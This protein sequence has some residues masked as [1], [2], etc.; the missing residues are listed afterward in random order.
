MIDTHCHLVSSQLHARLD[1]VLSN[2]AEAGVDGM[3]TVSTSMRDCAAGLELATAHP[4]VWCTSGIHPHEAD[5]DVDWSI[6]EA[7]ADPKVKGVTWPSARSASSCRASAA[8]SASDD[9][10]DGAS[11]T[12]R[13][14]G[15]YSIT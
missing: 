9:S 3:I 5:A 2:A 7:V 1:D 14:P 8:D 6:V 10:L 15:S 12:L 4:N 11:A 13:H